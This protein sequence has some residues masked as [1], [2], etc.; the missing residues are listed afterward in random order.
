M[1]ENE[2][3]M[4]TDAQAVLLLAHETPADLFKIERAGW[5]KR[6]GP[7]KWPLGPTVQGHARYWKW[8]AKTATTPELAACWSIT[9]QRVGQL[10]AEGWFKPL[11]GQRGVFDWKDANSGYARYL[12]DEGRRSSKYMAKSRVRDARAEE[13]MLRV[14]LK[15]GDL[16]EHAEHIAILDE[17]VGLFRSELSGLPARLTRDL[18]ERGRIEQ[19]VYDILERISARAAEAAKNIPAPGSS[20]NQAD[21]ADNARSMG[22]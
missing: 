20:G 15:S 22:E 21:A 14:G 1:A 9:K 4:M 8:K 7:D 3:G 11:D 18:Q 12:R 13:I 19:A 10:V 5:I 2:S 16:M 6:A 17:V